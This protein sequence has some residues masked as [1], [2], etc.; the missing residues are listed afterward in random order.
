LI[1]HLH[2]E[3]G[4]RGGENQ[5]FQ[6]ALGLKNAQIPQIIVCQSKSELESKAQDMGIQTHSMKMRGEIDLF[7]IRE[8][9]TWISQFQN[10]IVHTHSAHA[11]TLAFLAHK[12]GGKFKLI[13][14]RRVDF[15][16]SK[17]PLSIW[18]Y[19]SSDVSYFL[20]VSRKISSIL[21]MDG[22][23]P[24]KVITVHSGIPIQK[25]SNLPNPDSLRKE[26]GISNDT[27]VIGNIAAL[28][29]H[30]DQATMLR[31]ISEIDTS[32]PFVFLIAGEGKLEFKLKT[33]AE[34][35]GIESKVKFLGFRNDIPTLLSLFHIFTLT[36]EEEGLGTSILDAM[37]SGLPI[38]ATNAGGISEMVVNDK[39]GFLSPIK[40]H[41]SLA[42]QFKTLIESKDKRK[43]FGIFNR[44]EVHRFSIENTIS[45]T[46]QV[47]YSL[48]GNDLYKNE[49]N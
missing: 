9:K 46:I 43:E 5:L 4:W 38:I 45:K 39:G 33:L 26:L 29:N 34:T 16:L 11:H 15:R 31:A 22:V 7:F 44:K 40:D 37:A 32:T 47:Y 20:C 28:V 6:L 23:D 24:E 14:S 18:K 49:S 21:I 13:V 36:S 19:R 2:T 27:I 48:I 8:F 12:M 3:L 30:K 17:N 35:L 42:I 1:V 25:F 41:K 10:P